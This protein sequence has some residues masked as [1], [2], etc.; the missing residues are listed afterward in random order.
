MKRRLTKQG[1]ILIVVVVA[2]LI[3]G[4]GAYFMFFRDTCP[5]NYKN[6]NPTIEINSKFNYKKNIESVDNGSIKDVTCNASKLKTNKL[7]KYDIEYKYDG[8]TYKQTIEVV[9]TKKPTFKVSNKD[10]DLGMKITPKYFVSDVKDATKVSFSFKEDYSFKKKGKVKV[11]I[12]GTD[13]GGNKTSKNCVVTVLSKDTTKPVI[14][15]LADKQVLLNSKSDLTT[16]VTV[17]DNRDPN[18]TLTYNKKQINLKKLG[19]YKVTYKATDRSGNQ[20]T[21]TRKIEVVEKL[22]EIGTDK[23]SNEKIVYLTFDD[24]PSQNTKA[25]LDILAKYNCKATFFVTGTNQKCNGYIKEAYDAGHTIGLHTYTHDYAKVYA[26]SEAYFQD[27]QQV[28]DMVKSI[29]GHT[30]HYVRFPGGASNTVSR[31]YCAGI[32]KTTST[33]LIE[34]GYQYYDWNVSSEDASGN[35]VA[36]SRLIAAST[37]STQ[38]NIVILCHDSQAKKTTVEAL[39]TIIEHYQKLGY[40]FKGIDDDSFYV[41]QHINN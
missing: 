38:N 16:G 25:I 18:P 34:R 15:N 22:K 36:T 26:S 35:N 8:S 41:H 19:T 30:S 5:I 6:D 11:T 37:S 32:M 1:K 2:A 10:V 17:T 9:D 12:V 13:E 29:T 3:I 24:G 28:S 20:T 33:Q 27:L 40:K 7:G 4:V 23:Q 21:A 14:S 31:H 39:P